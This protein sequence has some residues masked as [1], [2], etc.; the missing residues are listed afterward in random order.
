[1]R[2]YKYIWRKSRNH[3]VISGLEFSELKS[4]FT[5]QSLLLLKHKC[6]LAEYDQKTRFE[7]VS[8]DNILDSDDQIYSWGDFSFVHFLG[9]KIPS[10]TIDETKSILYFSHTGNFYFD[11]Y[12]EKII[13]GCY[14]HDNGWFLSYSGSVDIIN[15]LI[16]ISCSSLDEAVD[17]IIGQAIIIFNKKSYVTAGT[18]DID[19]VLNNELKK[20]E[21]YLL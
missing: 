2:N 5:G 1:M 3:I 16:K 17:I 19:G 21:L 13:G 7:Y 10:F 9:K 14:I 6:E 11:F 12:S 15:N 18:T 20:I 4:I 8:I